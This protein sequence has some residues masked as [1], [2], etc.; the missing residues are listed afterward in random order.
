MTLQQLNANRKVLRVNKFFYI[1]ESASNVGGC[2]TYRNMDAERE[3]L[4]LLQRKWGSAI[5][6]FDNTSRSHSTKKVKKHID[7]NPVIIPP[8]RGV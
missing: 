4:V 1:K 7:F 3:Q 2:A 5:V 6:K 8:I